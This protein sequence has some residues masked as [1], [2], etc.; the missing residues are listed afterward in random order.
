MAHKKPEPPRVATLKIMAQTELAKLGEALESARPGESVHG[1]RRK[2]KSLRSLLRLMKP[3]LGESAFRAV[4]DALRDAADALAG[5]RRAEALVAATEK[6]L[7]SK[8]E[9]NGYW[10]HLAEAHREAGLAGVSSDTGLEA[11]RASL[12]RAATAMA[13]SELVDESG[14]ML[15]IGLTRHYAKA[16][17]LLRRGFASGNAE[18]LHDARKFV[19]HHLHH[20][21]LLAPHL[22][23]V[24]KRMGALERLRGFLG[25]LNDLDELEQLA[26]VHDRTASP[27][28]ARR[29]SKARAR[30]VVKAEAA[31]NRLFH[32]KPQ[33]I[34]EVLGVTRWG[35]G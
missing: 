25:D 14:D 18:D 26:R 32:Q 33:A 9:A 3:A 13:S 31:A 27:E 12:A 5:Q 21:G 20:L 2:I 11:A 35:S 28:A 1:A 16:R 24:R 10:R 6:F 15:G 29:M 23:P 7:V 22:A 8:E 30:L 34:A 19:I 17:R 4:N